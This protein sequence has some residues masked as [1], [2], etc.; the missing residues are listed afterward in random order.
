ML[1][2]HRPRWL[3]RSLLLLVLLGLLASLSPALPRAKEPQFSLTVDM[4]SP[5]GTV[6]PAL[7]GQNVM[8][9]GNG[10]WDTRSNDLQAG[11]S[12]LVQRIRPTVLRFPGGSHS[13]Q[14]FWEMGIGG[15]T[16]DTVT[17]ETGK[18]RLEPNP[19][20]RTGSAGRV[21]DATSLGQ[22]GDTFTFTRT[23][24]SEV[25]GIVGFATAHGK[26]AEVRLDFVRGQPTWYMQQY[27]I[28]EHMKLAT[29]LGAQTVITVN[30]GTG[31]DLSGAL[32]TSASL[33]QRVKRAA[34]W[35][36]YLNGNPTD[37]RD[38]GVDEE[39]NDW[40]RVGDWAQR[41][42]DRGHPAPYGVSY[43]EVG[44]EVY[45]NWEPGFTTVK[46]YA[47]D[48]L[49]FAAAM[50]AIDPSIQVGAV[51]LGAPHWRGD[52]DPADEWNATL[53]RT[54]GQAMDFLIVH[55][56]YPSA[57]QSQVPYGSTT[58]FTAV[59]AGARQALADLQEIRNIL[60]GNSTRGRRIGL[61]VT[62]Y[63]IWPADSQDARDYSNLGRALHDA[64]LLM[65]LIGE[66][67]GLQ[68]ILGTGWNLH[69]SNQTSLIGYDWATSNRVVR[70]QYHSF[71]LLRKYLGP[72]LLTTAVQSPTFSTQQVGNVPAAASIPTLNALAGTDATGRVTVLVLNRSL[73]Q[74]V[75]LTVRLLGAI[76]RTPGTARTVAGDTL[77]AHNEATPG[78]VTLKTANWSPH[79]TVDRTGRTA[80]FTQAFAARSL[81]LI[82]FQKAVTP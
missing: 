21:L 58:W 13:D 80:T 72:Q 34:A 63:G 81:T 77:A 73:S 3:G 10:M 36:A 74:E 57:A 82:E 59:M 52:A 70:P 71:Q 78:R 65:T 37:S 79:V 25:Q 75:T 28:D 45:G 31:R 39:G 64:D 47:Q 11:A 69:G 49:A 40:H 1:N 68:V 7:W 55:L 20:W 33:S 8:F 2:R 43:W 53:I 5:A 4:T 48:F 67:A 15:K 56:Y 46:H 38:I 44:N 35:V 14:Y 29:A 62:E 54:A 50:K 18:V 22:F 32:S 30:Y 12:P 24:G 23:A 51:G 26:G 61:A 19:D 66:G 9:T 41:R 27:G 60:A 42:A 6:N 76:P 16:L 17:T